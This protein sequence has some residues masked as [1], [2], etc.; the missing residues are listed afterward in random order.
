MDVM[1]R[2]FTPLILFILFTP[3]LFSQNEIK[4]GD[5][6]IKIPGT[7][8]CSYTVNKNSHITKDYLDIKNGQLLYTVVEYDQ[9]IPVH[10]EITE[11]N[12]KDMDK[13]SCSLASSDQ[14]STYT[15][16]NI[17]VIYLY[18]KADAV[19]ISTTVYDSPNGQ[20]TI[21]KSSIGRI[22]FRDQSVAEN[23]FD[24]NFK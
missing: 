18:T 17:Y 4:F 15:P 19:S 11:C 2:I 6:K 23:C 8:V 10:I 1:K 13:S 21:Q 3:L 20:A 14:K 7:E 5:K 12:M 16:G 22:H 9:G 24:V